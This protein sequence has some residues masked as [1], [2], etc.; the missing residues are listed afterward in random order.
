MRRSRS[1]TTFTP[2]TLLI[3]TILCLT[4][5]SATAAERLT[6]G[7]TQYPSTLN[8][9]I[10]SMAAKSYVNGFT[11]RPLTQFN[12][13]WELQCWLCLELP[14]LEAGTA[15]V[16]E[17][18]DGTRGVKVRYTIHPDARWG[19]GTPVTTRDVAFTIEVGKHE[20]S[21]VANAELYR[22]IVE[23]EILDDKT[24][25]IEDE[26]LTFLYPAI[27]DLRLLPEHLERAVFE[28]DPTTYRNRTL[29]DTD[30]TNPGLAMGPYRVSS[31]ET[32]AFIAL[33][34][35]PEWWGDPP[36]FDEIVIRTIENTAALEA[37]LLSGEIDM[38]EGS[39]G[40][41]LDQ[42]TAFEARHG[43]RFEVFYKPGLI[44]EHIDLNLDNPILADRRVRE[45]LIRSI[46]REA[47]SQQLFAGRQ[48]VAHTGVNP[49][50]WVHTDDIPTY[51][52]DLDAARALLDE[53]GWSD[54]RN[55][56]R[57]NAEGEPLSLT[58]MT[59]AGNRTRELVQQVLQS[60]W[61]QAGVEVRIQ[62]EPARVFF[63]ETMNHRRF[64]ALAM[65]AWISSPENVPR[66]TLHSAAIPTEANGWSGQNYPGFVNAEM[67]TLLD[68]IEITLDRDE[69][70]KLW[71]DLQ[72]LYATEL[73]AIPLYFR[74]D[75]HIWPRW[76]AGVAPTGH[77]GATSLT[78]EDW[79][80]VGGG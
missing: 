55:G 27:N 13:D 58:I 1:T 21:G 38:I 35:N 48:A 33:E 14:D 17:R 26:K 44:Y 64:S 20:Q 31:L 4:A 22:R 60:M 75:A 46:D 66:T 32:G 52:L 65:Y 56:V 16:V 57:H 29:F 50:D 69:R 51:T 9:N 8:P 53:A 19:D 63:G 25:V 40:L 41:A 45:A 80:V 62:N 42:A 59:T 37:N 11:H 70:E 49:L 23:L 71:H 73:P 30:P 39:L 3:A 47:L 2:A 77:M 12:A 78:V 24:F 36:A 5:G 74:A 76:L 10:D 43:E 7:I 28:T 6:I 79:H 61:Q 68:T 15:E 72:R 54:L 67:D 18:G 34:R